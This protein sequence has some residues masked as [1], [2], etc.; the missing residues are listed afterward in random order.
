MA[1]LPDYVDLDVTFLDVAFDQT[2][3]DYLP[4]LLVFGSSKLLAV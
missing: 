1:I 3:F 2:V 4:H